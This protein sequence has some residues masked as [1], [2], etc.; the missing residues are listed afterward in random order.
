MSRSW[1][2]GIVIGIATLIALV[3]AVRRGQPGA[4][5][6]LAGRS[7]ASPQLQLGLGSVIA[8]HAV[9]PWR[10]SIMIVRARLPAW[11]AAWSR[12][13]CDLY[14]TPWATFRQVTLPQILPAIVAGFLLASPSASTISSSLSSSP[15][16]TRPC[17]STSSPRSGAA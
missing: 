1:C 2:P 6:A 15:A 11:T 16:R 13:R 7:G 9:S 5:R 4:G 14:A 12:P 10:W 17:R 8:A 3:T